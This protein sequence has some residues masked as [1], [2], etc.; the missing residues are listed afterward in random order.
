MA[1]V[2]PADYTAQAKRCLEEAA[3]TFDSNGD[4]D[5]AAS[6]MATVSDIDRMVREAAAENAG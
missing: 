2:D 6:C 3:E 4:A 5:A 1:G